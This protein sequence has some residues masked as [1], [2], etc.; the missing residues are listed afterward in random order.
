MDKVVISIGGSV[1]VPD[2]HDTKYI[3]ALASMLKELSENCKIY[4]VT[5]G[6]RIAR[7][8]ITSGRALG[9]DEHYLDELGIEVT[10]LN[11]R[12]LIKAL[13][14]HAYPKPAESF[15]EASKAGESHKIV[16]MG[17]TAPG[18]TTDAVSAILTEKV[19]AV[20]LVNATNVDGVYD[21]DPKKNDDAKKFDRMSY[22]Q[23]RNVS[24]KK[25]DRAG[26]TV[27]FDPKGAE[28]IAKAKIPLYVC[29]G[30]DLDTLKNAI[31]GKKFKGTIV[32]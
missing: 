29:Q 27:I 8:Y 26:P 11:A 16:V 2:E 15:E 25:H 23:L 5:G 13:G 6:G 17:G 32:G 19:G 22:E 9:A 18:H 3:R 14:D 20:R 28:I 21:S 30:R 1:L 4:I 10:R 12:L 24:L 7:Y 31:L